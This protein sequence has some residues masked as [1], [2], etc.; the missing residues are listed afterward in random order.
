MTRIHP[1]IRLFFIVGL[2]LASLPGRAQA[3]PAPAPLCFSTTPFC[4]DGRFA[5]FWQQ[6]GGLPVFGYPLTEARDE[7]N[8]E[9]GRVYRTQWFERARFELHPENDAPYDVLLGRLGEVRLQQQGRRWQEFPTTEPQ[10]GCRF[11]AETRQQ[12]CGEILQAWSANGLEFDGQPGHSEAESLALFGL[13]LGSVQEENI[14]DAATQQQRSYQVQWFERARFE[15]HPENAPPY[16]V[17]LG[18]LGDEVREAAHL[19]GRGRRL[20]YLS[21]EGELYVINAD[22]S[23]Q[24]WLPVRQAITPQPAVITRVVWSPGP[25]A[26]EVRF[27]S[28]GLPPRI[29]SV[30]PDG[31]GLRLLA[32]PGA[33]PVFGGK[34]IVYTTAYEQTV[35]HLFTVDL[36]GRTRE[37][38]SRGASNDRSPVTTLNSQLVAF[39]S[40]PRGE[41]G[42]PEFGGYNLAVI[43]P[44]GGTPVQLS[45]DEAAQPA[46]SPDSRQLAYLGRNNGSWSLRIVN[47]D[48]SGPQQLPLPTPMRVTPDMPPATPAWSPDGQWLAYTVQTGGPTVYDYALML[49]RLS[50]GQQQQLDAGLHPQW[51][52]DSRLLAYTGGDALRGNPIITVVRLA[53]PETRIELASGG[54]AVFAP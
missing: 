50:T 54:Q 16:N 47:R 28:L 11:F 6:Q 43:D 46:W 40:N 14:F 7:I 36:E 4:I 8:R 38:V 18:R 23:G 31:S 52:S 45:T 17:L 49:T 30:N 29:Y 41:T 32:D 20:A 27:P 34:G 44:N 35:G 2:F 37:Q 1:I 33:E 48:G 25:L 21:P 5:E 3:Q 9:T 26:L 22:G 19:A 24:T 15:L 12:V 51:S 13:P 39:L 53:D 42:L 10:D